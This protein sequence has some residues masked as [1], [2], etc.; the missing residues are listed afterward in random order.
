MLVFG[1]HSCSPQKPDSSVEV[2]G[3]VFEELIES[4]LFMIKRAIPPYRPTHPDSINNEALFLNRLEINLDSV[5]TDRSQFIEAYE[6]FD[7]AKYERDYNDHIQSLELSEADSSLIVV[8]ADSLS[9]FPERYL[10]ELG[11]DVSI[12]EYLIRNYGL[13]STW[14][15]VLRFENLDKSKSTFFDLKKVRLKI[16]LVYESMSSG[17]HADSSMSFSKVVFNDT[18]DR[19]CF[20]YTLS[21]GRLCGTGN[22]VFIEKVDSC[23]TIIQTATVWIS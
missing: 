20:Y 16:N 15:S 11:N 6:A 19:G 17:I 1:I 23:W 4:N 22:L 3:Q 2:I 10:S 13:D 21:C 14:Q 9:N 5:E 7:W 12:N 8:V 18:F